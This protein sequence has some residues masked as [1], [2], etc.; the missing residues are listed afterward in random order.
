MSLMCRHGNPKDKTRVC[1][2]EIPQKPGNHR[3]SQSYK[4]T[5]HDEDKV[6]NIHLNKL[7]HQCLLC[8][9]PAK[10][11]LINDDINHII[12]RN[13]RPTPHL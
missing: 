9:H 4:Q 12:K 10:R 3:V 13:N 1:H 5:S 8:H 2:T 11:K 7:S 6:E